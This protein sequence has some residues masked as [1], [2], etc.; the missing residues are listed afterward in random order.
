MNLV[1]S[2]FSP[3]GKR[4]IDLC[5]S[6]NLRDGIAKDEIMSAGF[7]N[8]YKPNLYYCTRVN[9]SNS[10]IGATFNITIDAKELFIKDI[11]VLDE[12]TLQPINISK[13]E[14]VRCVEI[15]NMFINKKVLEMK[16]GD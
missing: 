2:E 5:N 14:Y 6:I 1:I 13:F 9:K 4:L 7:S 8:H 3:H 15:I 16:K 10:P 11:M 12:E